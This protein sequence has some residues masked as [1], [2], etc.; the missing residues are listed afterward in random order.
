MPRIL[1]L[2]DLCSVY[3]IHVHFTAIHTVFLIACFDS[4]VLRYL[5]KVMPGLGAFEE[6]EKKVRETSNE[7]C[8]YRV[9]T[10]LH[11]TGSVVCISF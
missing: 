8:I 5:L 3:I 6:P 10:E 1:T 4:A 9:Y 11:R 7:R 2:T